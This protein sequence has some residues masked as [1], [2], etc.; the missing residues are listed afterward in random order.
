MRSY[1]RPV[2]LAAIATILWLAPAAHAQEVT[3]VLGRFIGDRFID[4]VPFVP[5]VGSGEFANATFYGARLSLPAFPLNV[6][7]SLVY[8]PTSLFPDTPLAFN[9]K[10]V[11]AEANALIQMFPGPVSP[12]IT[13][14]IGIHQIDLE[15]AGI[16]PYRTVGYN[17][18][19]GV[20]FGVG[21][22]GLRI[23][24]RDHIT[25]LNIADMVPEFAELLFIEEDIR[26]HNLEVSAGLVFSF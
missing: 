10:V 16:S 7:G 21:T 14:G 20:K 11:Y 6:E 13:A 18:G 17:Y 3:V 5:E 4:R 15:L 25:P 12:F 19:A 26:L 9:A 1:A 22:L 8:S 24:V 23:D 2:I